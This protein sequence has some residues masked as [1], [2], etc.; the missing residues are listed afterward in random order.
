MFISRNKE[1]PE[2]G[3]QLKL[4]PFHNK[5]AMHLT[6]FGVLLLCVYSTYMAFDGVLQLMSR[7]RLPVVLLTACC[8]T[9]CFCREKKT[10]KNKATPTPFLANF[11]PNT[12]CSAKSI[13]SYL[14]ELGILCY[15][16]GLVFDTSLPR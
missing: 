6:Q 5:H 1:E 3:T 12:M 11:V 13:E 10:R 16:H 7:R 15:V 2:E 9:S 14:G 8:L 4:F